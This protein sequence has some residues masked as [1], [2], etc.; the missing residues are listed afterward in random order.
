MKILRLSEMR[1]LVVKNRGWL[2][3]GA[4]VFVG[5]IWYSSTVQTQVV[6]PINFSHDKHVSL[7]FPCN[8][9]HRFYMTRQ[10]S[11]RPGVAVCT[12]CH[13]GTK[14]VSPEML[15]LR[16]YIDNKQEIPWRRVYEVPSRVFYSHRTHV[17]DGKITCEEC[18]G[19]VGAQ[20]TALTRPLKKITMDGCI[21]C[22]KERNITTDCNACHK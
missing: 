3:A 4:V 1:K 7:K 11:G 19:P 12:P 5:A 20:K 2:L 17:V 16:R 13:I 21:A 8:T 18:H 15:K 9:C 22:H 6:Q 14:P 10:T